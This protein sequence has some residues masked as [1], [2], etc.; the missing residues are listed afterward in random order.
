MHWQ[1]VVH[2]A[3]LNQASTKLQLTIVTN[4][5]Y[6]SLIDINGRMPVYDEDDE[7]D[8]DED[9]DEER[10]DS[11]SRSPHK[12]SQSQ[13]IVIESESSTENTPLYGP[14]SY[15]APSDLSQLTQLSTNSTAT[16]N[17]NLRES[18]F[19][20]ISGTSLNRADTPS[21]SLDRTHSRTDSLRNWDDRPQSGVAEAPGLA[22]KRSADSTTNTSTWSKVKNFA[23]SGSS[24][25]RRSRSNSIAKRDNAESGRESGASFLSG[26]RESK[27]DG[28]SSA[29]SGTFV[30]QQPATTV[31]GNTSSPQGLLGVSAPPPRTGVSPIPPPSDGD[32]SRYTNPKLFP[33]PGIVKLQEER[34]RGMSVSSPDLNLSQSSTSVEKATES[35]ASSASSHTQDAMRER[36]ISHQI[37][38]SRL[39]QKYQ[40]GIGQSQLSPSTTFTHAGYFDLPLAPAVQP[41]SSSGLP[42]NREGVRKWLN[43][44]FSSKSPSKHVQEPRAP[45][46]V[47]KP[48][49]SDLLNRRDG[50]VSDWEEG[51]KSGEK[52]RAKFDGGATIKGRPFFKEDIQESS[53]D[54]PL[55]SYNL[56]QP[57]PR[58][59]RAI[60]NLEGELDIDENRDSRHTSVP[61]SSQDMVSSTT[62]DPLSSADDDGSPD[63]SSQASHSS[64]ASLFA[65]HN[66]ALNS[67]KAADLMDRLDQVLRADELN[68]VWSSALNSPPRRLMLSS[69]MLQVA[70]RD[71]VKDRFL[72]LFSDILIIAKPLLPD[73]DS[74]I[75]TTKL[76]APDRKFV[77]K[78][79][80]HLRDIR[81]NVDRDDD[82]RR[83]STA[84]ITQRPDF[85]RKFIDDFLVDAD[86]AIARMVNL[87]TPQG[88]TALGRL[89]VQLPELNKSKLGE[90]L[91]RR[92]S[93]PALKAY[94]DAFGFTG[95]DICVALRIFLLSLHIPSGPGYANTLETLLDTFAGRWYEANAGIVAF[96]KGL[97]MRLVRA[98]VRLHEALHASISQ[99]SGATRYSGHHVS[100]RDFTDAFRRHDTHCLVPNNL[101]GEIYNSIR[102]EKLC[103]AR[104]PAT[105]RAHHPIVLRRTI[106]SRVTYRRQ[107]EPVIVR[108][109][110][111]DPALTIQLFGQDLTFEPAV[112]SFAKSA[113]ASFRI[114]GTGL[115]QKTVVMACFGPNAPNYSGLPLSTTVSVERAFMR[116]TFQIAF[117]NASEQK[118][119]YMFSVDDPVI[120]N[121]WTSSLKRQ[122]EAARVNQSPELPPLASIQVYQ[123]AELV[124]FQALHDSLLNADSG[125][126]D[127][128]SPAQ[129]NGT[130]NGTI[131]KRHLSAQSFAPSVKD[132]YRRSQS[133]SQTY[134]YG[135]GRHEQDL[136]GELPDDDDIRFSAADGLGDPESLGLRHW[137]SA[138]LELTCQQNSAISVVL[139]LLQ[140]ALPYDGDEN[141]F[142]LPQA[143]QSINFPGSH[144]AS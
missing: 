119:R 130:Q 35:T 43:A 23:R 9:K 26:K 80:V 3:G 112:L 66:A 85:I 6:D 95:I 114:T 77:I 100:M 39:L 32:A 124:S 12:S 99:D 19:S 13:E 126:A 64:M 15:S 93:R 117:L 123:A 44:R 87:Q 1:T 55:V 109:P 137:T 24:L 2:P 25:G 108:L 14:P 90:Y 81:L 91:S 143:N 116:N 30:W 72:F 120:R 28:S 51:E 78:N 4:R 46:S 40:A 134:R 144:M 88:Y 125:S 34:S 70:N 96:G 141:A 57:T 94:L 63:L 22:S 17:T 128:I 33:F 56:A 122:I 104:N 135:E 82:P 20:S 59:P 60:P 133:R 101:L 127:Y 53:P 54:D 92:T 71:T 118:R 18:N 136:S 61:L 76:Y 67:T 138:D 115:G 142:R 139:S 27:G 38:D 106:P 62:P 11:R 48:S 73:R 50:D 47:K 89:L 69:P 31:A 37:S 21:Q 84:M 45:D 107:S 97:A 8:E 36:R 110:Q 98:I 105:G 65:S 86:L 132:M 129:Q 74:L 131:G 41:S 102:Y 68:R 5:P 52:E 79:V 10:D 7:E 75:D 140:A 29:V 83:M 42:F 121:E 16:M 103:Q 113:E 111:P 58:S 49:L